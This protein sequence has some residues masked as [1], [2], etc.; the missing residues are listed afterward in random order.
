MQRSIAGFNEV[1]KKGK[2]AAYRYCQN[3]RT[4]LNTEGTELARELASKKITV[5]QYNYKREKINQRTKDLNDCIA[6]MNKH[7]K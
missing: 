6:A 5:S 3:W 7:L 4:E 2:D 1:T